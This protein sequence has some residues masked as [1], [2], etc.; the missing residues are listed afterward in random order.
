MSTSE[1]TISLFV[2]FGVCCL[3]VLILIACWKG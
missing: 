1:F 2:L 3:I